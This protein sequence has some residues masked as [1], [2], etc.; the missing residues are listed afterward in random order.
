[1]Q[2]WIVATGDG[3]FLGLVLYACVRLRMYIGPILKERY[4][5][6]ARQIYWVFTIVIMVLAANIAL[7]VLQKYLGDSPSPDENLMLEIWFAVLALLVA[8]YLVFGRIKKN[9]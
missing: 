6:W 4:G 8:L 3:V 7:L 5:N 1:M 9:R 2:H